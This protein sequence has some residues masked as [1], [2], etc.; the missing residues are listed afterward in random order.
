MAS[1]V[2]GSARVRNDRLF[3]TGMGVAIAIEGLL[4]PDLAR[5]SLV[6]AVFPKSAC[7]LAGFSNTLRL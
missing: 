1:L 3:Y 2:Q 5:G 4:A 7:Y 6:R